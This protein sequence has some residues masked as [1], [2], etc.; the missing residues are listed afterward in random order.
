MLVERVFTGG[1][2]PRRSPFGSKPGR[3]EYGLRFPVSK[4][5]CVM[6]SAKPGGEGAGR[7]VPDRLRP[8]GKAAAKGN[9]FAKQR[10]AALPKS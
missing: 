3:A 8:H 10:L 2:T 5:L 9:D 4:K 7:A 1:L 6:L